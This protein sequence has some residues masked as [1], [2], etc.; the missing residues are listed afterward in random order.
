MDSYNPALVGEGA[1]LGERGLSLEELYQRYRQPLL[2]Y[3]QQLCGSHDQAEEL[4]QETFARVCSSFMGFRGD[5]SIATWLFRIARN[6]YLNGQRRPRPTRIDTD[7]LL[8]I[9]DQAAYGDPVL[10][11]ASSEERRFIALA[12]ATLPERQR[13]IL[14]L[15]DAQELSYVEIAEVLDLSLASVKVNLFRARNAFR[16]VYNALKVSGEDLA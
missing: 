12:L 11:Y 6:V 4:M 5:S 16:N 3:L 9:P 14:L 13:S 8:A 2:S 10:S 1:S 7:D 15:R